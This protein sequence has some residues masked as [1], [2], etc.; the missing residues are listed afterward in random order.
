[1]THFW[2]ALSNSVFHVFNS[3]IFN[4]NLNDISIIQYDQFG[5]NISPN[6][7][8]PADTHRHVINLKKQIFAYICIVVCRMLDSEYVA[9]AVENVEMGGGE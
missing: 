4:N 7:V 8:M 1:M 3:T 2:P 9:I 6:Y 5:S